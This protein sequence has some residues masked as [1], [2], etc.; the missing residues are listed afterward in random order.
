MSDYG[1][2]ATLQFH[3]PLP[4][5]KQNAF[6]FAVELADGSTVVFAVAP[7]EPLIL[8]AVPG[9]NGVLDPNRLSPFDVPLPIMTMRPAVAGGRHSDPV[10]TEV[11]TRLSG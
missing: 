7:V 6:L 8:S 11:V 4:G 1:P 10:E 5:E 3:R 2:V 9:T